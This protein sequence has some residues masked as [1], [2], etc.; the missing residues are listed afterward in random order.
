MGKKRSRTQKEDPLLTIVLKNQKMAM[1]REKANEQKKKDERDAFII[2]L[3]PIPSITEAVDGV[4]AKL[5]DILASDVCTIPS[6]HLYCF[7]DGRTMFKII[8]AVEGWNKLCYWEAAMHEMDTSGYYRLDI[9]GIVQTARAT[10]KAAMSTAWGNKHP[11]IDSTWLPNAFEV[12]M[13][14]N[15]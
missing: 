3:P 10:I 9:C 11:G 14:F 7:S 1:E 2:S 8:P 13:L 6:A 4:I 12:G 5:E 15:K